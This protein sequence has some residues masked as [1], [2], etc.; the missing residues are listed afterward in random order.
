MEPDY[1]PDWPSR[2]RREEASSDAS[3]SLL[4]CCEFILER[5]AER[6]VLGRAG[7]IWRNS[8]TASYSF[9]TVEPSFPSFHRPP[10]RQAVFPKRRALCTTP[11]TM[12]SPTCNA[13]YRTDW[14][15]GPPQHTHASSE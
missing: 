3:S 7:S 4:L 10:G 1:L 11:S 12:R 8:S 2:L 6:W 5:S 14:P 15:L 13:G 9:P